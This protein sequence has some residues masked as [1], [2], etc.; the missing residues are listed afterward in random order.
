MPVLLAEAR[1]A[2]T[3]AIRRALSDAGFDD[4]PR[5]GARVIGRIAVGGTNVSEV[6]EVYGVSKQ[7]ASQLVDTLVARGYVERIPD[8]ADRRRML[9]G[10]S[11]RGEAAA[12]EIKAAVAGVDAALEELVGAAAVTSAR[13]VLGALVEINHQPPGDRRDPS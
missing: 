5:A 3:S 13:P 8:E 1:L 10:L 9:V 12:A 2:Y 6:A 11:E 4:I 7:A